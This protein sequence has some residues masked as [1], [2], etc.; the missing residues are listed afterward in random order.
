MANRAL[1]R[2][3]AKARRPLATLVGFTKPMPAVTFIDTNI[4]KFA[5]SELFRLHPR[6]ETIKWG[7]T[8]VEL[9]VHDEVVVNPNDRI[10]NPTL[11]YEAELLPKVA[12]LG[13][14]GVLDFVQTVEALYETWGIPNMDSESGPFYGAQIRLL[15]DIPFQ[16][17]R[18]MGGLGIDGKAEQL[19]F[20]N[21]I[22][23]PR[24][25]AIQRASGAF[26]GSNNPPN[27][28]QLVD[29]FHLWCAELAGCTY[30]LSLDF[31]L[32]KSLAQ[33]KI[34]LRVQIVRPSELLLAIEPGP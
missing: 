5:A 31:K 2:D 7:P 14:I 6:L 21:G 16:Y 9:V 29:A 20:I 33:S 4:L 27:S 12:A 18:V 13:K 25:E 28:N 19:R 10:A 15:K 8:T 22:R 23:N 34:E 32:Q 26:Q 1:K 11:K 24:F 17:G 30:F 3:A